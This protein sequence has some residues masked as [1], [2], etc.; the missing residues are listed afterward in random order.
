MFLMM[1]QHPAPLPS[2]PAHPLRPGLKASPPKPQLK[3]AKT[4]NGEI[5]IYFITLISLSY[6]VCKFK[7]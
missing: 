4:V 1:F 6:K 5:L 7:S 2:S 3:I